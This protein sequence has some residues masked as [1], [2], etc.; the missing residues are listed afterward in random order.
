MA[1]ARSAHRRRSRCQLSSTAR[2]IALLEW[3]TSVSP[4]ATPGRTSRGGRARCA[5]DRLASRRQAARWPACSLST[6]AAMF[7]SLTPCRNA[8][9]SRGSRRSGPSLATEAPVHHSAWRLGAGERAGGRCTPRSQGALPR[10]RVWVAL[11]GRGAGMCTAA[12]VPARRRSAVSGAR[13]P[14]RTRWSGRWPCRRIGYATARCHR[15]RVRQAG[16]RI[17]SVSIRWP[18]MRAAAGTR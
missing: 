6:L 18:A 11:S 13:T 14:R 8:R 2:S 17:P 10:H 9:R 16:L 7:R 4:A 15:R 12:S 5:A 3:I 1:G